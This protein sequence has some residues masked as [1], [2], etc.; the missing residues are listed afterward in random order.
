MTPITYSIGRASTAD[1]QTPEEQRTVSSLHAEVTLAT[2]GR[3]YLTDRNS[4]NGTQVFRQ[5]HWQSLRQDFVGKDEKLRLGAYE[6]TLGRL[7]GHRIDSFS[8]PEPTPPREELPP[9]GPAPR[10]RRNPATGE[11]IEN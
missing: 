5:N 3:Y 9:P 6:T 4:T 10:P 7:L 2:D 11:V 1:I 8:V